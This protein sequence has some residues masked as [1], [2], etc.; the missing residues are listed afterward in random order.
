MR[1]SAK[2]AAIALSFLPGLAN[3]Q[4]VADTIYSGGPILTINDGQPKVEAVA[5]KDGRILAAGTLADISTF[6]GETTEAFDLNGRTMLP[7]FVDS[8]GH[9]VMG[10]IQALSANL[11]APPDG[12]VT[13]IASLQ[14]TLKAWAE[15]NAATVDKGSIEVGKLAGIK[16]EGTVKG[17]NLVYDAQKDSRRG[18]LSPQFPVFGNPEAAHHLMH[19][20]YDGLSGASNQ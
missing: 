14:A 5:V 17:G 15:K 7:G 3:A 12:K 10:G 6:Q 18:D 9:V 2:L 1:H 13:D 20:M 16:I 4:D 19:A 11:L 8:H